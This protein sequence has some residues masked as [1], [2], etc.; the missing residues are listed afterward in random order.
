[1]ISRTDAGP[2]TWTTSTGGKCELSN[3]EQHDQLVT[4][5]GMFCKYLVSTNVSN[6]HGTLTRF[7]Y[8]ANF[9]V[10]GGTGGCHSN[11][12]WCYQ[13]QQ[14]WDHYMFIWLHQVNSTDFAETTCSGRAFHTSTI[15]LGKQFFLTFGL[16]PCLKI[17]SE[18]HS[19]E[20]FSAPCRHVGLIESRIW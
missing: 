11:N 6:Y 1:M 9:V 10:T 8:D 5:K 20:W 12:P 13:W 2:A 18:C 16:H 4:L 19:H 7:G 3:M 17:F 15:L 14:S